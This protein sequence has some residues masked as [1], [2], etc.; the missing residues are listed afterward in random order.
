MMAS[1]FKVAINDV[2]TQNGK[3]LYRVLDKVPGENALVLMG[4]AEKDKLPTIRGLETIEGTSSSEWRTVK[5]EMPGIGKMTPKRAAAT[6]CWPMSN[7][8]RT[9]TGSAAWR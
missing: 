8:C 1:K 3:D 5:Y 4:M 2:I 7:G 6:T 9:K